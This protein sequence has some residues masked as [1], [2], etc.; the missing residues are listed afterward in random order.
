MGILSGDTE[1]VSANYFLG[2]HGW[3]DGFF[4]RG[5]AG[6]VLIRVRLQSPDVNR[7]ANLPQSY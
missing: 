5:V 7:W 3:W 2:T 1:S 6:I 4:T